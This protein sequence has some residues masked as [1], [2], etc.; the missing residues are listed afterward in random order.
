MAPAPTPFPMLDGTKALSRFV[1]LE[2]RLTTSAQVILGLVS[3]ELAAFP[4][5]LVSST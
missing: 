2:P 1:M 5:E 4:R 3:K